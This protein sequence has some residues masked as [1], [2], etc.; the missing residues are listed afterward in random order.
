[1]VGVEVGR[2]VAGEEIRLISSVVLKESDRSGCTSIPDHRIVVERIAGS[3]QVLVRRIIAI[4]SIERPYRPAPS[5]CPAWNLHHVAVSAYSCAG[6]RS[7]LVARVEAV[8]L[9]SIAQHKVIAERRDRVADLVHQLVLAVAVEVNPRALV[10]LDRVAA[11]GYPGSRPDFESS[12]AEARIEVSI[13]VIRD[14]V[15]LDPDA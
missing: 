6:M 10:V 7:D 5:A 9:C 12:R 13:I 2:R 15:A 3:C 1:M 11:K 8:Q 14:C 4:P